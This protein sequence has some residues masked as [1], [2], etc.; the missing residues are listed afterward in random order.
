[1]D[2]EVG[3]DP[4]KDRNIPVVYYHRH[5]KMDRVSEIYFIRFEPEEPMEQA[6]EVP[7]L[8]QRDA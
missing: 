6:F 4:T 3:V 5:Q 1:M 8:C 7:G 2:V